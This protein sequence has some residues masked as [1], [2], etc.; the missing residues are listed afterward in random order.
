MARPGRK[1]GTEEKARESGEERGSGEDSRE[2]RERPAFF[3]LV[4]F[5]V[6]QISSIDVR[7]PIFDGTDWAELQVGA[8]LL[9][10]T[11]RPGEEGNSVLTAHRS[12]SEKLLFRR[13]DELDVGD[14]VIVAMAEATHRYTVRETHL[15]HRDDVTEFTGVRD[16]AVLTLITCHPLGEAN[17]PYRIVVVAEPEE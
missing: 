3:H 8:G 17:P 15:V 12:H 13:L 7:I 11:V 6:L 9:E 16:E 5:G 10:E 2:G 1:P 4:P 14:S